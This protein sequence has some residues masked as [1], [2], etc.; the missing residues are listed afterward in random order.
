MRHLTV[1]D[2]YLNRHIFAA[3]HCECSRKGTKL[4]MVFSI[5]VLVFNFVYSQGVLNLCIMTQKWVINLFR[6]DCH[7]SF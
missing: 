4:D 6:L 7:G 1:E 2:M 3:F 5:C